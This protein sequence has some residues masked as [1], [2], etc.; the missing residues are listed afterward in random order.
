MVRFA[1]PAALQDLPNPDSVFIGGSGGHLPDII[2]YA[3]SRLKSGGTI[4][5][6]LVVL[7]HTQEA[8]RLL[9]NLGLDSRLT[10]VTSS[11]GKDMPDGGIRL[12]SL[13]PVFIVSGRRGK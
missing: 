10:Q 11:R 1:P 2:E 4:I 6:N 9:K 12:E 8:Y 3:A 5:V 13:N 7:D